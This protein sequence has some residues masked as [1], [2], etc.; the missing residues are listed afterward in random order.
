MIR[1]YT[2]S[3]VSFKTGKVISVLKSDPGQLIWPR[4][5]SDHI[6]TML[7]CLS[8][9]VGKHVAHLV[10]EYVGW[11]QSVGFSPSRHPPLGLY[12]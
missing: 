11:L 10:I 2:L 8:R 3:A 6:R 1:L 4:T 5:E 9:I 12:A 7:L